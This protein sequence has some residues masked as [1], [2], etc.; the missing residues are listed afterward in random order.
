MADEKEEKVEEKQT[1]TA[2]TEQAAKDL[3]EK[4]KENEKEPEKTKE[5]EESGEESTEEEESEEKDA[6]STEELGQAKYI[7]KLLKDPKTALPA[8]DK[9]GRASCRERV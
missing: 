2:I 5:N 1:L 4:E 7:Y 9:I 6:L 8:L 3:A